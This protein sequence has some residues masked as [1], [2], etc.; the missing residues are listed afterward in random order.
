M[1]PL[2]VIITLIICAIPLCLAIAFAL[3]FNGVSTTV[4]A[5]VGIG[6][7]LISV[8]LLS[9]FLVISNVKNSS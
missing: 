4:A 6:V 2:S 8:G 5:A 3:V 7:F 1:F 9:K